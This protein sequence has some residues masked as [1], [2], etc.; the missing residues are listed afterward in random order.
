MKKM[1]V[2]GTLKMCEILPRELLRIIAKFAP[3]EALLNI[4]HAF[5]LNIDDFLYMHIQERRIEYS[6]VYTLPNG[7]LY[8]KGDLPCKIYH[9]T[10]IKIWCEK[11]RI[12]RGHGLPAWHML[13]TTY[14]MKMWY[15]HGVL[16]R[17][18]DL[19]AIESSDG[20]CTWYREGRVHRDKG[21]ALIYTNGTVEYWHYGKK[22]PGSPDIIII[23]EN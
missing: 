10:G 21:P 7:K 19:P 8:Q 16:H 2:P 18:G 14:S 1:N 13:T 11:G 20:S 3:F 15:R 5:R 17:D 9:K 4:V 12:S 22:V 6:T 23:D